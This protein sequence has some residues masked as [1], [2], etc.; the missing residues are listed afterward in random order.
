[1]TSSHD[2]DSKAAL[3]EL[4]RSHGFDTD[5]RFYRATLPEFLSPAGEPDVYRLSAN[6]DPSES[7]VNV[8][9]GGHTWLAQQIGPGLAFVETKDNEWCA[10]ERVGVEVRLQDVLDQ[11]G[12]IY[13]VE[14]VVTDRAWYF[15]LP[16]GTV[17]VRAVPG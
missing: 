2:S 16:A 12:L 17:A 7:V 8:Y 3:D 14:S 1:M 11:G 5:S 6:D 4:M 15:T 13:P 10:S 9:A